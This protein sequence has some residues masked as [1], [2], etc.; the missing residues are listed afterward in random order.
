ME[1]LLRLDPTKLNHVPVSVF[2]GLIDVINSLS[3][4]VDE[5][6]AKVDELSAAVFPERYD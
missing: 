2:N 4:D 1:H 6:W 3:D 5:M